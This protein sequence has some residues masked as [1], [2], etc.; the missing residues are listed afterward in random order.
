MKK[1]IIIIMAVAIIG[2]IGLHE[3]S[4]SGS[5]HLVSPA[6]TSAGTSVTSSTGSGSSSNMPAKGY[7]DGTFTGQTEETPYGPVQV[8]VVVSGGKISDVNFLQMPSDLAHSQMVTQYSEPLLKQETLQKQNAAS[9]D[10]V[11]GAT[12]TSDG[13]VQSL[14]AALDQAAIS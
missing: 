11:S 10:F 5:P 13:Y 3:K 2:A 8:S 14:Q 4:G 9:L 7:K 12:V 6:S 1:G